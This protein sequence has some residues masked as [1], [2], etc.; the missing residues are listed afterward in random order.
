M[1]APYLA[2]MLALAPA[3]LPRD[4]PAP[5]RPRYRGIGMLVSS[6]VLGVAGLG[7]KMVGTA[8]D[9][10]EARELERTPGAHPCIESCYVGTLFNPLAAPLWVG[11]FGLL[12]GGMN[13][14][15]R[16]LATRDLYAGV[17]RSR[18]ARIL[19]GIGFGLLGV[20]VATFAGFEFAA[21]DP[22]RSPTQAIAMSE[23]AWWSGIALG[24]VGAGLAG[25][26]TGYLLGRERALQSFRISPTVT[27]RFAGLTIS[28]RF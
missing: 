18:R 23:T 2:S 24:E 14:R 10:R 9:P 3:A 7:L 4:M 26:G 8:N 12:G 27:A 5:P 16:W 25:W 20:G 17:D 11:S 22:Q 13:M 19:T 28:G 15:A 21:Y 6:G 1:L